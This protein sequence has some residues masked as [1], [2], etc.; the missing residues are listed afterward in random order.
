MD[1]V[2][3]WLEVAA[4]ASAGGLKQRGDGFGMAGREM[5]DPGRFHQP[6]AQLLAHSY[7]QHTAFLLFGKRN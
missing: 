6:A 3:T 7:E 5:D 1:L 2:G 4:L